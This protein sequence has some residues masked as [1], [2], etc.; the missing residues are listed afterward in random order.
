[1]IKLTRQAFAICLT[2]A[3]PL[4]N[5]HADDTEIFYADADASNN[6]NTPQANVMVLLD[7]SGSMGYCKTSACN[8]GT[9]PRIDITKDAFNAMVDAL[10]DRVNMG[11]TRFYNGKDGQ[12]LFPISKM[13]Q[14]GRAAIKYEASKINPTGGTPTFKAY[15]DIARYMYGESTNTSKNFDQ[16]VCVDRTVS[17]SCS[18]N[19]VYDKYGNIVY[20]DSWQELTGIATCNDLPDSMKNYQCKIGY[21]SWSQTDGGGTTTCNP[22]NDDCKVEYQGGFHDLPSGDSCDPTQSYCQ[23]TQWSPWSDWGTKNKNKCKNKDK[24]AGICQENSRSEFICTGSIFGFCY[25]GY[26]QTEYQKRTA[27]TFAKKDPVYYTRQTTVL[28]KA[29]KTQQ[30]CTT[31]TTCNG[32][33]EIY[34]DDNKYVS[35]MNNKNECEKNYIVMMTD[36]EPNGDSGVQAAGD[37]PS[38][39]SNDS[40][41]STYQSYQCQDNLASFMVGAS[42]ADNQ[43]VK[44]YTVGLYMDSGYIDDMK[45]VASN[46]KG[47]FYQ[48]DDADSLAKAFMKI[49]DL[50]DEQSRSVSS[51]GVAVNQMNRFEHLDQ[52]YYSIF[53]PAISTYWEGNL[54]K[55]RLVGGQIQDANDRNAVSDSTGYFTST[56]KSYWSDETDGYDATKGGARGE[57]SKHKIFYDAQGLS[58]GGSLT[59][60]DWDKVG[61]S[62][63]LD[64]TFFGL[65]STAEDATFNDLISKLQ[66]LWSDPMHSVPVLVNYGGSSEDAND[67]NNVIF[68]STNAGMLHAVDAKTGAEK[69]TFMPYKFITE[70]N[71]FTVNRPGLDG[72]SRALYGLDGS[73]IA[74][75]RKNSSGKAGD[76]PR[77]VYLYGGMRRGGRDYYALDVTN[78]DGT[79]NL[80]WHITGGVG[81]FARLGQTWSTPTLTQIPLGDDA[82]PTPVLVFGG[83]YSPND[84]D[85]Q[86]AGST[87]RSSED[88]MGNAIYIVNA[89]TGDLVWSASSSSGAS[90]TVSS[91]K[92]AIPSGISVVD[93]D[94]DG[95]ADNL[96]FGDLGGQLF[97]VDIDQSGGKDMKVR[98]MAD[99]GGDGSDHRRFY[100]A[101]A[102]AYVRENNSDVFYVSLGSGYRAH[103]KDKSTKEAFFVVRDPT[104]AN[105]ADFGSVL[106]LDDLTNITSSGKGSP[107]SAGWYYYLDNANGEKV[108]SSPVILNNTIRFSTYSPVS[109]TSPDNACVVSVGSAYLHTVS[110]VTGEGLNN[111]GTVSSD[112][113]EQ[114][115]QQTP[116]PTPVLLTDGDGNVSVVVGTEVVADDSL[117][118]VGLRKTRWYQMGVDGAGNA[119][120]GQ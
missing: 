99:L 81:D 12:V 78:P 92:W 48:A 87:N 116:P 96:Y 5:A 53:Q 105:D 76:A 102:V 24:D 111:D 57:V 89:L 72:N 15:N 17:E 69:F 2:L 68:V 7:S 21:G 82:T 11:L 65:K 117:G 88:E 109:T 20:E 60:V 49:V 95:V 56:S 79:P 45:G 22:N 104:A 77:A 39:R 90:K 44:T 73:W 51:P 58:N 84:H 19:I 63:G 70:A 94:L 100:E 18:D 54:K 31:S 29:P 16:K 33:G 64:R 83:G 27:L 23:V 35:P 28:V 43:K 115:K 91:M 101:P 108:M 97:R 59:Q 32:Y 4:S 107:K 41:L 61:T 55:Y 71:K 25:A 85:S 62:S 1:M 8:D 6:Q 113:R 75:R 106:S 9:R 30:E 118:N 37:L 110:L 38:C 93:K 10:P 47:E 66:T 80:L 103:P 119:S 74:W 3:L 34:D 42:K 112:R 114:L 98:R 86:N 13:S 26:Y 36:G 14:G 67:Q 40:S 46:G 50:V 120:G 52:L